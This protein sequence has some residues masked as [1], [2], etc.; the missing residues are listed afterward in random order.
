MTKFSIERPNGTND[1]IIAKSFEI[2]GG[3]RI[4]F[5]HDAEIPL[6]VYERGHWTNVKIVKEEE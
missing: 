4:V 5:Y 1:H 6:A 3:G 2:D